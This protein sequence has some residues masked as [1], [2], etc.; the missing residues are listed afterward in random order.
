MWFTVSLSPGTHP[1]CL[2]TGVFDTMTSQGFLGW[3][4]IYRKLYLVTPPESFWN[5][6][7][8]IRT[9][10]THLQHSK[11]VPTYRTGTHPQKFYQR[12]IRRDSFHSWRTG[13]CRT[14]MRYRG[15]LCGTVDG[16]NP[17]ALP[18]WDVAK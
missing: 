4:Y 18:T 9:T 5:L 16:R 12:A 14:G 13:D 17:P 10:I 2:K 6:E 15:V 3:G 7:K 8:L 1:W 11:V